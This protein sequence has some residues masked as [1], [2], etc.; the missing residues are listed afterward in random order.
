MKRMRLRYAGRCAACELHLSAGSPAKYDPDTKHVYCVEHDPDD[1]AAAAAEDSAADEHPEPQPE[2]VIEAGDP[3]ASA[4]REHDR[5]R[6]RRE[7]TIRT[8]HP[9]VGGLILALTD[10][11]QT[12]KAW[13]TG[14]AGEERLGAR[15]NELSTDTLRVL[16]DRRIPGSR[17]NIDHLAITP[18]GVW[19]VDAKKYKGRPELRIEGGILRPRRE[20]VVVG[21]R[22]QT[23]LVAGMHKQVDVVAGVVGPDVPVHGVLCF[24]EAD[25][26][27]V[28]G[29]FTTQGVQLLW[30]KKL[31]P[32]LQEPGPLDVAAISA[33]HACLASG[34]PSA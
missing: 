22:D 15:L 19:V 11:P 33:L 26:P 28:G 5:R 31:Y 29:A 24:V 14:A 12:T 21:G 25:W 6:Q 4:R 17:A 16:H 32:K 9:K 3:G 1:E 18:T 8:K 30:P 23:K 2:T 34:L 27:L 10:D 7:E 13:A 20:K